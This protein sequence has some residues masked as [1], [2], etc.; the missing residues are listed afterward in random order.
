[1]AIMHLG[2][3]LNLDSPRKLVSKYVGDEVWEIEIRPEDRDNLVKELEKQGLDFEST[4][5]KIYVFHMS[6]DDSISG[7]EDYP[8]RINR[9]SS[10]L[11]DVFLRLTG[12]S[13]VE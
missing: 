11:E 13:L 8:V 7:L 6:N 10:S 9:R 3:I 4:F 1:V 2:K 5:G 12:R